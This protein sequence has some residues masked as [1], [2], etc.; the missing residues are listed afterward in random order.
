MLQS[1]LQLDQVYGLFGDI[2][3]PIYK[4][5]SNRKIGDCKNLDDEIQPDHHLEFKENVTQFIS[6]IVSS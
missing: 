6:E 3:R 1:N 5:R 2:R 4:H